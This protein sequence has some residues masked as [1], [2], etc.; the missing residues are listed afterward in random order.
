MAVT[1]PAPAPS[2]AQPPRQRRTLLWTVTSYFGE[3]LPWTVLHQMAT[4]FLTAIGA[5][6]TQI[7]STSLFH[8]AVTLKF[9]WSPLVDLF[10]QKRQWLVAAQVV[11]GLGMLVTAATVDASDLTWFWLVLA[12]L[13][14]VHA[15][16]DIACDGFYLSALA[17]RE[18]ALFS[19]VRNAAYR[20]AM[21]VGSS[22]LV[23]LA[24]R[25]SW[26]LAFASAGA[27][28]LLV[29]LVNGRV[30]PHPVEP[31]SERTTRST[32]FLA[33]Y[34]TFFTQ[35]GASRVLS[36]ILL[37][38]LGDIMM[39]AMSKPLL[40]DIG[41]DTAARGLLNGLGVL[42]SISGSLVGGAIIARKGLGRCLVPMTYVQSLAIPLYIVLAVAQP[43]AP[44]VVPIVVLEQ[45]A[46]GAGTSASAVF[47]MQ[48]AHPSFSASHFAF[49]TAVVSLGS[50]LSGYISGPLDEAL[51]H[52]A[53][54]TLAFIA[55]WPSLLLVHR[56]PKQP[57]H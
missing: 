47:L 42:A 57:H 6:K 49:A 25:T 12:L 21:I 39:F 23:Y 8:L 27:L 28:M 46:A 4:E 9:V 31:K 29:A 35:P 7:G 24:G 30:L 13:S 16:H 14:V 37:Y 5:S 1:D 2:P 11:L 56:V 40:K 55:S 44:W 15:T 32:A 50:S 54:F 10:G 26:M 19:G 41:M 3:G 33:A 53:F 34:R 38:R 48:I 17:E 43:S 45:L 51:G 18:R 20:A 52:P 36:F 22:L